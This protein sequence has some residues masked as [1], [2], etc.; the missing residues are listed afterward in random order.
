[1]KKT[2]ITISLAF[3]LSVTMHAQ[4]ENF[5]IVKNNKGADLG[6]SPE[7]GIKILTINGK[8]FKDLNKNGKLDKYEDWRLSADE[9]AKDLAS[10]MSVEQIAGLM[11]YSR[12]QSLPAGVSGYNLGTYDGKVFPESNAKAY[13]LADQQKAFLKEDNLRHV[14][15]TNVESPEVAALWN[16]KMQAFVEGIGLGIPSN[17]STDP[18]HLATVTSEFN[19]GAGGTISMWPDGLGMAA[20]FDPKIVEQFGQIAAKEYRALGIATALSPQID[21]GTEPRWYRITMTFGESPAL[22]RDMGRAY[23]DGFQTSYGKDEIKDG[24]GYKSV[25]AMVKHW[26]SGGAEEGGRDGHWA[27]GKFAVYPGNNLQQHIDPFVNGAFKLKGKTSKASA[28]MPY[29]TITFDQDK[30]Y[31]ENVANGYSKYIITDLLRDKY[32]YDGVVCTDWLITGDEGKTPNIFAGK[33]WGVENLSIVDRHY[34]AIMAGVDQFGG[35]NDKKPVLAAYEIGIKEYGESFM[36][37]RFERSAVRL[38]KNIF[39]VG[40]FENP[41]LNIAET[42]EVVGN[43]KFMEAGYDAQLKSIVLLKNK[44]SILPLKEKK[45]VFIPKIYTA[46]KKDWW[47]IGS[48]PKLEHPVNLELIKKYYNVTDEPSKADFAIVFVTSPQSLEDGYDLNDRING[49]NG[50][51]PI[52]L[53]YGTYTATEAR[54]KSIAAGDQVIDPNITNRTYKNKTATVANTMDL[55]TILDTKDMMGDKPVIVSV[56]ASKPMIFKE[57][58]SQVDGIV[59]NF[60]VSAQAVLDIIS[61][62]TEPSGLLPVQMPANMETVEKQFEDVPFDMVSHKDSEGNIYDF[63]YG[64]NWKGVI[65]D[66]RT[67]TYKKE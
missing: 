59:L 55:R 15:I 40:L 62:K 38:L 45:T 37:A 23:I 14:L 46:S 17:T 47:G 51:L 60:G 57:F 65:K 22:T 18:R 20:T 36:R 31:N 53:Q 33:P 56:T 48:M 7:S 16:N 19:A 39:R 25:N 4:Q 49:S 21:L 34:K 42:N 12:H 27:Y 43:S 67:N 9:R 5:T 52:S 24:W 50:Y 66:A 64:L 10:K 41:Y 13:D 54:E 8:K 29:Y 6:Y 63:A 1:M 44:A 28:V 11:L 61:G 3:F 30:K 26:P 35:N 58:E 32:G 2:V